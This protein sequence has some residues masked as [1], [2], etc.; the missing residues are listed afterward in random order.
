MDYSKVGGH[1]AIIDRDVFLRIQAEINR[2]ANILSG[3]KK[4]I[5][6]SK[7]RFVQYSLLWSLWRYIPQNKME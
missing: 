2:R 4:R 7:V 3:G 5:Y 1:D 6:G